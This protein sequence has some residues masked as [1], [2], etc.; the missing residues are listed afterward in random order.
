MPDRKF[1]SRNKRKYAIIGLRSNR[2][3]P[4]GKG[5]P[6]GQ[7][8]FGNSSAGVVIVFGICAEQSAAGDSDGEGRGLGSC[9]YRQGTG[10]AER[11]KPGGSSGQSPVPSYRGREWKKKTVKYRALQIIERN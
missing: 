1:Y 5:L 8:V 3:N 11:R 6:G 10:T 4:G 7:A 2:G 9:R